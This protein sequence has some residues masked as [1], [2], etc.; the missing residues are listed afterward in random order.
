MFAHLVAMNML[1]V[2]AGLA[3]VAVLGG[4]VELRR[5]LARTDRSHPW[6]H[7]LAPLALAPGVWRRCQRQGWLEIASPHLADR[8]YYLEPDTQLVMVI[9]QGIVVQHAIECEA[10]PSPAYDWL[11]RCV[12]AMEADEAAWCQHLGLAGPDA[13]QLPGVAVGGSHDASG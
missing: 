8:V 7:R 13:A 4:Q 3:V 9:Q 6:W 2:G 1:L 5:W 10:L 12:L 11:M